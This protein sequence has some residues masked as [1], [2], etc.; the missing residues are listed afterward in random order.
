MQRSLKLGG[1]DHPLQIVTQNQRFRTALPGFVQ[2]NEITIF[3]G[4]DPGV[5]L[6]TTDTC[7]AALHARRRV[8]VVNQCVHHL[9]IPAPAL[10]SGLFLPPERLDTSGW[11]WFAF[12]P[13]F[14]GRAASYIRRHVPESV[15]QLPPRGLR[16]DVQ[17]GLKKIELN[18]DDSETRRSHDADSAREGASARTTASFLGNPCLRRT[19]ALMVLNIF[20]ASQF[21]GLLS[22]LPTLLISRAFATLRR[23]RSP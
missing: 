21:Y 17:A 16:E 3:T 2:H 23:L 10:L 18:S 12:L 15:H 22:W 11:Q 5:E 13:M 4:I 6:V 7:I 1:N 19:L 14:G 20:Q 8:L 9:A